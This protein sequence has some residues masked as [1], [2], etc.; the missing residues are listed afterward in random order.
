MTFTFQPG[1]VTTYRQLSKLSS[2]ID[3]ETFML[4]LED[5]KRMNNEKGSKSRVKYFDDAHHYIIAR[6]ALQNELYGDQILDCMKKL[7]LNPNSL[8]KNGRSALYNFILDRDENKKNCNMKAFDF[9]VENFS[10]NFSENEK[11]DLFSSLVYSDYTESWRNMI[12][13]FLKFDFLNFDMMDENI[14]DFFESL[15]KT[16]QIEKILFLSHKGFDLKTLIKERKSIFDFFRLYNR[17]IFSSFASKKNNSTL[18]DPELLEKRKKGVLTK[19]EI[20]E[21]REI[22][23]EELYPKLEFHFEV[24][25]FMEDLY[26]KTD[27]V[28]LEKIIRKKLFKTMIEYPALNIHLSKEIKYK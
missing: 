28:E 6:N 17:N 25:D 5:I 26:S 14:I 13:T 27:D 15:A 18:I 22:E 21:L 19:N 11:K 1:K 12:S 10:C 8:S 4:I 20:R 7:E 23:A 9:F 16:N 24:L 3:A 2:Q